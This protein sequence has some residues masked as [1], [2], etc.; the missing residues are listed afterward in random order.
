MVMLEKSK[1]PLVN[2][3]VAHDAWQKKKKLILCVVGVLLFIFLVG[4]APF[5]YRA[6][7]LW[8]LPDNGPPFD[9]AEYNS[10]QPADEDNAFHYYKKA[11]TQFEVEVAAVEDRFPHLRQ[12]SPNALTQTLNSSLYTL[13]NKFRYRTEWEAWLDENKKALALWKQGTHCQESLIADLSESNEIQTESTARIRNQIVSEKLTELSWMAVA[14]ARMLIDDGKPGEAWPW[15]KAAY[16]CSRHLGKHSV[17]L[18]RQT[19]IDIHRNVSAAIINHWASQPNVT[20]E[21]LATAIRDLTEAYALT[22]STSE[23]LKANYLVLMNSFDGKNW[24]KQ[25][26]NP[27]AI[28]SRSRDS[29]EFGN[30]LHHEPERTRRALQLSFRRMIE[31]VTTFTP[32]PKLSKQYLALSMHNDPVLNKATESRFFFMNVGGYFRQIVVPA[33]NEEGL[34]AALIAT[35]ASQRFLKQNNRYPKSMAE[36]QKAYPE[37][38]F[39]DPCAMNKNGLLRYRVSKKRVDVWSVGDDGQDN[40]GPV[41][42]GS[43]KMGATVLPSGADVGFR[44]RVS[45]A[46]KSEIEKTTP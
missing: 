37:A 32:A 34:Q 28:V 13:S 3:F 24:S 42:S 35:L 30:W 15:Y 23:T 19:G 7:R 2:P 14:Q 39:V 5:I 8:G 31:V 9:I 43:I 20:N 16:R 38:S 10:Y 22:P 27:T 40:G 44:L 21:Q 46:T 33:A 41:A 1:E 18:D 25:Y 17:L 4:V 26:G 45:P 6:S 11:V 29:S 36:L 12:V